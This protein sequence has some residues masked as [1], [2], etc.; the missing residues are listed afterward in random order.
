VRGAYRD[1][2]LRGHYLSELTRERLERGPWAVFFYDMANGRLIDRSR[3][4]ACS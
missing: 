3:E 2:S 1:S 4:P